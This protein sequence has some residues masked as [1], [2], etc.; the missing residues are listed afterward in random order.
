MAKPPVKAA[1]PAV[2]SVSYR[3]HRESTFAWQAYRLTLFSDSS[4]S[5]EK[6]GKADLIDIVMRRLGDLIRIEGQG[7][8]LAD[9]KR[10]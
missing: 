8:F 3:A 1:S 2:V 7:Q 6:V 10:G 9:K 4:H 5:E